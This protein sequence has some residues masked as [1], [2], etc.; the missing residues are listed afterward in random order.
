MAS[1]HCGIV[2]V[3]SAR[4]FTKSRLLI[5]YISCVSDI[6]SRGL[7]TMSVFL[8][9]KLC[10]QHRF[11]H[12]NY[13]YTCFYLAN[14]VMNRVS[15]VNRGIMSRLSHHSQKVIINFSLFAHFCSII[16]FLLALFGRLYFAQYFHPNL[17]SFCSIIFAFT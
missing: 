15:S 3:S 13:N 11:S 7:N 16:S 5:T 10:N 9:T 8:S 12:I 2:S 14:F 6:N 17:L 1:F 4:S